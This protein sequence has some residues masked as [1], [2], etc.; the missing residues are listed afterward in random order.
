MRFGIVTAGYCIAT[1][2]YSMYL[3]PIA[4]IDTIVLA[5]LYTVRVLAGAFLINVTVS[6]WLLAFSM[7]V[8]Y[9]LALLKRV[10]ELQAF[11]KRGEEKPSGRG[12]TFQD[13]M[14]L[15]GMGIASGLLAI[16][17][18][19]LYIN[20]SNVSSLYSRPQMLWLICPLLLY[21]INLLWLKTGRNEMHDDPVV[22]TIKNRSSQ[23]I[24][25][26]VA[27]LLV[28]AT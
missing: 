11:E 26:I 10:T 17:V 19:A 2:C 7:F 15:R 18:F 23:V 8:F 14:T 1:L 28:F 25:G 21:W 22:F 27:L 20:S 3:K 16:V 4:L 24:F 5:M 9:C 6:F 12:Y 13:T